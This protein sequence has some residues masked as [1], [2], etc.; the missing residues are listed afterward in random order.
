[1]AW[2]FRANRGRIA[3]YRFDAWLL[4]WKTPGASMPLAAILR[5]KRAADAGLLAAER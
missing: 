1:M 2:D 3:T 5:L 4:L